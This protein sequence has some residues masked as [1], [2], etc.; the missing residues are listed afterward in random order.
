MNLQ[1]ALVACRL[2]KPNRADSE[3]KITPPPPLPYVSRRALARVDDPIATPSECPFCGG[4]VAYVDHAEIYNGRRFGDWPYMLACLSCDAYVGLHPHTDIPLGTLADQDLRDARK[5]GK[6]AFYEL[7]RERGWSR[8]EAYQWLGQQLRLN[9]N[10]CHWG[11]F[12]ER[13]CERA[14]NLCL[15]GLAQARKEDE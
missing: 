5:A 12:D 2:A 4:A 6:E 8:S 9:V 15:N 13:Q 11:W 1:D 3:H 10:R 14:E 7:M